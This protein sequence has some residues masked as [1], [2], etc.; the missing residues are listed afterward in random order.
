MPSVWVRSGMVVAER[1]QLR[2]EGGG[3]GMRW[4][5]ARGKGR[6]SKTFL[7]ENAQIS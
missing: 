7:M 5:G 1:I 3:E 6:E 4:R 2:S